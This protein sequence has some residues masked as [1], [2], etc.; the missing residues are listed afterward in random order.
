[1]KPV[2]R[3]LVA[4]ILALAAAPARA[5]SAH[6][7]IAF[8]QAEEGTWWCRGPDAGKALSCALDK[9]RKEAASP[10]CLATRWC[11]LSGWSGL[12]VI[13]LP[14]FHNTVP[15]CGAPSEAAAVEALKALC[16]NDEVVT[17]CDVVRLIDPDGR[18]KEVSDM[19]WPGPTA[20]PAVE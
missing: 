17:R 3:A 10:E 18:E 12:M 13:W 16:A 9:C 4:L 15:L 14:E 5:E 11:A 8:A 7:G 1:M 19:S 6:V 20:A 2:I